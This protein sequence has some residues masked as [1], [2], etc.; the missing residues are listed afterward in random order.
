ML[1]GSSTS[2]ILQIVTSAASTIN[3][4]GSVVTVSTATP[5]VVDGTNTAPV[6]LAT[7]ST[8]TTTSVVVGA[9]STTKRID[10]LQCRNAN[11]S[12]SCDV[13]FQRTDGTNT[14]PVYKAT[15]LAGESISYSNGL[16]VHYDSNGVVK[17]PAAQVLQNQSTST[18]SAGY[19]SD[20]YL[21]G[22]SITMP[23]N[24]PQV[25]TRYRLLFDMVKTAAGTATPIINVR[26][27][28]AGS[29]A[30]TAR[31]TFTFAAGTAAADTGQFELNLHF[32]SVGSGTSAVIVGTI[33]CRHSL[34][35]TGLT[36]TGAAGMGQ[37]TT[38][39]SGFDSTPAGSILGVS[40]NGG[41]SFS[42]TNTL[43]EAQLQV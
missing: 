34:A 35:A 23:S 31:L 33:Q 25:G 24:G 13:T 1:I 40:F 21:A 42:G 27:G 30:D 22:S 15:L 37:F 19:A 28:T 3:V 12:I 32:R 14:D 29:T 39:S 6:L 20:T 11:A 4:S 5:P 17:T 18:V 38:V 16:W 9:A 7:I 10:E 26:F 43:V 36:S 41:A 2:H 8:A